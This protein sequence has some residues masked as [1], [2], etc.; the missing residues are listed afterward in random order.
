MEIISTGCSPNA[1]PIISRGSL[2]RLF[3]QRCTCTNTN[4]ALDELYGII[5]RT[6]TSWPEAAFI[7]AGNFNKANLRKV[8]LIYYQY[9]SCPTRGENTLN[10]GYTP[11]QDAHKA[12]PRP[13]LGKSDNVSVLLLSSHGQKLKCDREVKQTIP[14]T[15]GVHLKT[16]TL[17]HTRTR[18]LVTSANASMM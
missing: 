15:S 12:V 18:S 2:Q 16:T 11:F 7:V 4:Q 8:L 1:N 3:S 9:I 14:H 13:P 10:H 6:E 5:N 17:T